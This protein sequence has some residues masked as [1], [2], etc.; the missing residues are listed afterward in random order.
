[1]AVARAWR[2]TNKPSNEYTVSFEDLS[3][4]RLYQQMSYYTRKPYKASRQPLASVNNKCSS[5]THLVS[6][7]RSYYALAKKAEHVDKDLQRAQELY[8]KA[9][10]AEDRAESATKDLIRVM[11]QLG[12]TQDAIAYLEQHRNLFTDENKYNNLL[13]NLNRQDN[14]VNKFLKVS[15]L[16]RAFS[17]E[18][19]KRLFTQPHR[20]YEVECCESYALLKFC[21]RSAARKTLKGYIG[22]ETFKIEWVYINGDVAGKARLICKKDNGLFL[23]R[24]FLGETRKLAYYVDGSPE[25]DVEPSELSLEDQWFALGTGLI[26]AINL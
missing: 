26:D 20:I 17:E 4:R 24:L 16:P 23:F 2:E 22:W 1:M 10:L 7:G 6:K 25:E 9:V 14:R 19:V 3:H 18:E 8:K 13:Q 11:Q 21:S 5:C 15:N 12:R